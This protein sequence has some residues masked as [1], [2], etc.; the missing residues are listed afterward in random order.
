[1]DKAGSKAE[2]GPTDLVETALQG[3]TS[4]AD[5]QSGRSELGYNCNLELSGSIRAK[6]CGGSVV[7]RTPRTSTARIIRRAVTR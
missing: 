1:M 2:C 4:V 6:A 5:R 3:Q 7:A